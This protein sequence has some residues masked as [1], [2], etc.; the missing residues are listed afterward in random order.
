MRATRSIRLGACCALLLLAPELSAGEIDDGALRAEIESIRER[1]AVPGAAVGVTVGRRTFLLGGFGVR[2]LGSPEPVTARTRFPVASVTKAFTGLT[3]ARLVDEGRLAWDDRLVDRIDVPSLARSSLLAAA[4]LSDALAHRSGV[5]PGGL[6][7]LHSGWSRRELVARL[8]LL[9]ED[10]SARGRFGYNNLMYAAVGLAIE[11]ETGESWEDAAQRLV[12]DALGMRD[13]ATHHGLLGEGVPRVSAHVTGRDGWRPIGNGAEFAAIRP[14]STVVSS[15]RDLTLLTRALVGEEEPEWTR[16][17]E[18]T[19][20]ARTLIPAEAFGWLAP[21]F[22]D[23]HTF[24]Y[25]RGWFLAERA[26]RRVVFHPGGGGGVSSLLLLIPAERIGISVLTND[27]DYASNLAIANTIV[28]R[29]LTLEPRDWVSELE[30]LRTD[31]AAEARARDELLETRPSPALPPLPL[32]TYVG[33]YGHPV[34]GAVE[35]VRGEGGLRLQRGALGGALE[36]WDR[37]SFLVTYP[38][39]SYVY[40]IVTFTIG[41][42]RVPLSLTFFDQP[43]FDRASREGHG[44]AH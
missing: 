26:G 4:T 8:A 28:D 34:Y 38:S 44:H 39:T 42:D 30:E 6:L 27:D 24:A 22:P 25:G 41:S 37:D 19:A 16:A 7:G 14:A 13:S 35:I 11:D 1:L 12:I 40:D 3:V 20:S 29:L 9:P 21:A 2:R 18:A 36:E 10:P 33:R 23:C 5:A 32:E 15:A 17:L 43:G 31:H